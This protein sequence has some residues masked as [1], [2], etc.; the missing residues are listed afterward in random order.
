MKVE[1]ENVDH[2][3]KSLKRM[4]GEFEVDYEDFDSSG[5]D[6]AIENLETS[7]NIIKKNING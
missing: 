6:M 4:K 5:L 2:W 7:W 1:I 3:I